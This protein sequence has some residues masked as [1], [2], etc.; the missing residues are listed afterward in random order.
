MAQEEVLYLRIWC[1]LEYTKKIIIVVLNRQVGTLTE[2]IGLIQID[3]KRPNLALMKLCA[4]HKKR[5]DDVTI[6]DMSEY[7]FDRV[8]AS[9]V[10]A[11]GPG[12]DLKGELPE[13]IE[14]VRPDYEQFKID[15]SMGFT[16]RGCIRDCG[17]CIVREKEG[18]IKEAS[19]D[20]GTDHKVVFFDNNFLASPKCIE[21]LEYILLHRIKVS[22]SQG[23]DIRLVTK[24]NARLLKNIKSYDSQFRTRRLCFSFDSLKLEDTIIEKVKLLN[25]VGVPSRRMMIYILVGYDTTFEEDYHR[26]EVLQELGCKPFIM[27]YNNMRDM[28]ILNHF[29]RWVNKLY[30]QFVPWKD[31]SYGNSQ[32]VIKNYFAEQKKNI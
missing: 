26:F 6:L 29:A 20:W 16:S 9:K 3:G 27:K 15:Y 31:Y 25:R 4:W 19:F 1:T 32:K 21:K 22:F 8:Y 18:S 11:G 5:G 24:E 23:L 30:Y 10:F 7:K 2:T 28:P 12:Y 17:F 14:A 13:E